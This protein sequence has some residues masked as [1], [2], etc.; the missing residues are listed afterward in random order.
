MALNPTATSLDTP[1]VPLKSKSP[2][3]LTV[4]SLMSTPIAVDTALSVTPAQ[5]TNASRSIS[6][7]Q[8]SKPSPP[9]AG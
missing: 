8:A 4:Q 7:E 9:V 3:A 1:N 6:P 2:S 5:A